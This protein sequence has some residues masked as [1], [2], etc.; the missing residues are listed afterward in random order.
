VTYAYDAD[1]RLI[2]QT[3]PDGEVNTYGYDP[4]G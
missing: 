3:L 2:S 4:L 1:G